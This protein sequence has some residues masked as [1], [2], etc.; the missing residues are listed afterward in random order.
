M[1]G[2]F[3]NEIHYDN[4]STDAGERIEIVGPA[5][6]DLTGWTLVRYNGSNGLVYTSPTADNALGGTLSDQGGGFGTAVVSYPSNGLQNGS[7]DAIAL[8]DPLGNVVQFLSYEG[9]LTAADGPAL[10]MTSTDIG[11]SQSG[12][13]PV[14]SALQLTGTGTSY[15]DFTWQ[16]TPGSNT[17]GALNAGQTFGGETTPGLLV[18]VSEVALDE[19]GAA[20][21]FTVAL[22]T[23]PTADVTVTLSAP[24]ADLML[25]DTSLV[26]TVANWDQP[27]PVS[28]TAIEDALTEGEE[29]L[30]IALDSASTDEDYDTLATV[31][32][33]ATVDDALALT[34]IYT[35]QGV[36]HTSAL[37][38]QVVRSSGIVTAVDSNGY[39]LQDAV[40]DADDRTSDAIFVFTSSRP[41]VAVGDEVRVQG[42]VSE[43]FPGGASTGNLSTTQ[44]T[45]TAAGSTVIASSGNALPASV[46]LGEGGR[47]PPTE[48]IEDDNF[49][50][51][52]IATDGIDFFESLEAMRVTLEAPKVVGATNGFGEIFAIVGEATSLSQRGTLN[53]EPGTG[54]PGVTNVTGGDFNPERI[55]ID[56]DT[57]ILNQATPAADVGAI[58]TDVTGV[59]SYNF[60]NYEV[61]PTEAYGVDTASTLRR[62]GTK[63]RGEGTELLIATYNVLNLDPKVEDIALVNGNSAANVD[64]DVGNGQFQRIADQIV[65]NLRSPDIIALQE[66]QDGDGGEI[67]SLISAE[68]TLQALV[69]AIVLA[70]GP[71]YTFVDNPF[72]GNG[73]SGGQPGGNIRTAFLYDATRVTLV[74][75]SLRTVTDPAEQQEDAAS[76]F[77]DSRLPLVADF[78][79]QGE[80]V[81]V[82]NNHLSSKG[83]STPLFGTTQPPL[84]GSEAQRQAQA[85]AL[86]DFV[87]D[88]LADDADANVVVLGDLNEFEFEEPLQALTGPG[89]PLVNLTETLPALERYSYNFEG[90]SQSLDHILVGN[91]LALHS[92]FDAVHVNSEFATQASDHDPLLVQI[93]LGGVVR[94][95][96]AGTDKLVGRAGGDT[97]A[98]AG[99]NDLLLG[100]GGDD[101]LLGDAGADRLN[102]GNGDDLIDGGTEN[103]NLQ[104]GAG[105]DTLIGG[106]G[107]D[108]MF[109]G[110]GDDLLIGGLG[111]DLLRGGSGADIFV[112]GALAESVRGQTDRI[113][114][115]SQ[116]DGDRISFAAIDADPVAAGDQAFVFVGT[117]GF[118]GGGTASIRFQ[119]FGA[120]NTSIQLDTGNGGGA[121]MIVVLTGRPA[122]TVDDFIL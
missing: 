22:R 62:E 41:A 9:T 40:G 52:D 122:L 89:A 90:N 104:G 59:V 49:T 27:Q 45:A 91:G 80:V 8:V 16:A 101:V 15:E 24:A 111:V 71:S 108:L 3:V 14:D 48:V 79:F 29:S 121:E 1:S 92:R 94:A 118:V 42:T 54:G 117:G 113:A 84:N 47:L 93:A 119:Q 110:E 43:F 39:Y 68:A 30:S 72:I 58:L 38:G 67:S 34:A 78:E 69:D 46:L 12:T 20:R 19:G 81:T 120:N 53:I 112:F 33:E 5:G 66:V 13:D 51:F 70:G 77:F 31:T 35:I 116:A 87:D 61:L 4:D 75:G 97:L 60:G 50:S 44:I 95:G 36:G 10:G 115:F 114:D 32:I 102:G 64:D 23:Q 74:D 28:V 99:G 63:L 57:G 37:T 6:T 103:D 88:L 17:F 105:G 11:V 26:F 65:R 55:Q 85:E 107:G 18:S 7:P 109:G 98:G 21:S 82:V 76:P 86:R 56:D 100:S 73:T 2:V 25:S 96:G 106:A 83:G